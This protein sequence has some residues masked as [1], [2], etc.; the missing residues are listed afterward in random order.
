M[1]CAN[2]E[3][4]N[5][6]YVVGP[7]LEV[8]EWT[9]DAVLPGCLRPCDAAAVGGSTTGSISDDTLMAGRLLLLAPVAGVTRAD[10][11]V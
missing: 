9:A 6:A 8:V 4:G 3:A 2:T 7:E 10:A 11:P 1:G 5:V